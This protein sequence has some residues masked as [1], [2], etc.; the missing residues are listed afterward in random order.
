MIVMSG[1]ITWIAVLGNVALGV[2]EILQGDTEAGLKF[3]GLAIGLLGL[4]RK[5]DKMKK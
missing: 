5:F 2:V 4:G 3:F 1:W